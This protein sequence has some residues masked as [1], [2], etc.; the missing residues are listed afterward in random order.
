MSDIEQVA[1]RLGMK[2]SEVTKVVLVADGVAV[3][4]H[5]WQW[6]L[7]RNDG[8]LVFGIEPPDDP[9]EVIRESLEDVVD[10]AEEIAEDAA[11]TEKPAPKRRSNR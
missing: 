11:S 2:P 10:L 8:E 7:I 9:D 6:M 1:R 5:D 4:T 3:Q